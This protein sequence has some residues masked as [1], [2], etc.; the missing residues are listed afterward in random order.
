MDV[1]ARH[2]VTVRGR[3]DGPVMLF[4][5]GF[6]CDQRMWR[7][8]ATAFEPDHRVVLFDHLGAG[9][10]D[11]AAFDPE[12]HADLD[13]YTQD[14]VELIEAL[15]LHDV[16]FVGHSVSS[17]IGALAAIAR[18]ERFEALVMVSPSPR[19]ID[20]DHYRGGFSQ[21]DIDELLA[22]MAGNELGWTSGLAGMVAGPPNAD[23]AQELD[24]SF[25]R[26]DPAIARHF[27]RTVFLADNRDDLARV[28]IR[29]LVLQVRQDTIAPMEVGRYV[30]DQLPDSR[31]V[32]IDDVGHCPH[33]SA[34]AVTID[35]IRA[36]VR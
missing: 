31:L 30:H 21:A 29:S 11:L 13:G 32:L 17:M 34:P 33:L 5:H 23:V 10:S 8:V 28:P 27:A 2:H 25:C 12:R 36:F 6:G 3:L 22:T 26:T 18:P 16:R 15:D 35:A 4:A 19:Y 24:N 7:H 14:V 20:T 9:R 1:A